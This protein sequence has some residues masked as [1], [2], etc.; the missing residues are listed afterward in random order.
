MLENLLEK[1]HKTPQFSVTV[2]PQGGETKDI[3]QLVTDRIMSMRIDDNRG[4]VA[5]M[6]D[7]ELSDQARHTAAQC[8]FRGG[9][10]MER[11][12]THKQ[13]QIHG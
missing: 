4:F 10:R 13:R 9:D 12:T 3:T 11:R 2:T 8:H 5:A 7:L 1:N 6:L